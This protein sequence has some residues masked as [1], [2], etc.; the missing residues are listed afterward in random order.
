[1]LI[2]EYLHTVDDKNRLSLP[3]KFRKELGK[4]VVVTRG[5]DT[6]LFMFPSSSW[7]RIAEKLSALPIGQADTRGLGRFLLAGAIETEVDSA[8]RILVPEYLRDFAGLKGKVVVAGVLERVELWDE[9]LWKNYTRRVEK[10]AEGMAQ[11]LGDL[12]IL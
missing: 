6:C 12:G 7:Q 4:K 3:A 9:D 1:M 10:Q 5:L 11:K 2:G 8:G